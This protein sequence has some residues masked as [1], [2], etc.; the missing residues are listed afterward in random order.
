MGL[1][2]GLDAFERIGLGRQRVQ[3]RP[4]RAAGISKI[5]METSNFEPLGNRVDNPHGV[6]RPPGLVRV[7]LRNKTQ[8]AG[9]FATKFVAVNAAVCRDLRSG[10]EPGKGG[11]EKGSGPPHFSRVDI[12]AIRARHLLVVVNTIHNLLESSPISPRRKR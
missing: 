10:G 6:L 3:E 12:A 5:C 4:D 9:V 2:L 1:V 7:S 8:A 11:T